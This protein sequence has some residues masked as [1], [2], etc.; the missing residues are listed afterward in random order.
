MFFKS[1]PTTIPDA[2]QALPGRDLAMPVAT[3]HFVNGQNLKGPYPAGAETSTSL[4]SPEAPGR[5]SSIS[6]GRATSGRRAAGTWSFVPSTAISAHL[7]HARDVA[8]CRPGS[9]RP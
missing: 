9:G 1:K 2:S 7:P 6:R 3:E 4:G 5:T 8:S